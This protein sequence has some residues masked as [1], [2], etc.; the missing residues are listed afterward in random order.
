MRSMGKSF[1]EQVLIKLAIKSGVSKRNYV[2]HCTYKALIQ[3]Y[4]KIFKIKCKML[5][6]SICCCSREALRSESI[7]QE[8]CPGGY[9]SGPRGS[10]WRG[11]TET[12]GEVSGVTG[13]ECPVSRAQAVK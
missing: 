9:S 5:S 12:G 6:H 8:D 4:V 13:P 2:I 3:W 10:E 7:Q 1:K 11:E